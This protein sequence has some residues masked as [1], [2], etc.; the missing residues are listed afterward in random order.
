[1]RSKRS[2]PPSNSPSALNYKGSIVGFPWRVVLGIASGAFSRKGTRYNNY[3]NSR[4]S[5]WLYRA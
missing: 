1:V 3:F 4:S 5:I 2:N